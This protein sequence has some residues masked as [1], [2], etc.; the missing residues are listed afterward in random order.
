MSNGSICSAMNA[1]SSL[2]A[3][4]SIFNETTNYDVLEQPTALSVQTGTGNRPH[5]GFWNP[6]A[7]AVLSSLKERV[8][9]PSRFLLGS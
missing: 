9:T 3:K 8:G 2:L 4:S 6:L 1:V 5:C 7:G